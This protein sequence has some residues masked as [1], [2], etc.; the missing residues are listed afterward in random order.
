MHGYKTPKHF[1]QS[2][3]RPNYSIF[4]PNTSIEVDEETYETFSIGL[5]RSRVNLGGTNYTFRAPTI[6]ENQSWFEALVRMADQFRV[7]PLLEMA[8]EGF[9]SAP[10][11]RDLPP[12]PNTVLPNEGEPTR[13]IESG[14]SQGIRQQITPAGATNDLAPVGEEYEEEDG[15]STP[16]QLTHSSQV[17]HSSTA[18]DQS[19]IDNWQSTTGEEF[20]S[21][22]SKT[23]GDLDTARAYL[24][25]P[26]LG[27]ATNTHQGT[28]MDSPTMGT[29]TAHDIGLTGNGKQPAL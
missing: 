25:S 11:H 23:A 13:A 5:Q 14:P 12:L 1:Q 2:P 4:V 21:P 19:S 16:K 27:H 15:A 9:S 6:E 22:H 18:D 28:A 29:S 26:G 17:L 20:G 8:D 7:V 3:L 24:D 10:V